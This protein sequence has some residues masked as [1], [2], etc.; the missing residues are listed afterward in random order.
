MNLLI[1]S[2]GTMTGMHNI[3]TQ[4]WCGSEVKLV[5]DGRASWIVVN[6]AGHNIGYRVVR[7]SK[8]YRLEEVIQ[9]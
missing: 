3:M 5:P 7:K 1:A 8:R 6:T 2:S 4:Y 9:G